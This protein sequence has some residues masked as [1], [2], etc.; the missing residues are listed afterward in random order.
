[1]VGPLDRAPCRSVHSLEHR[2]RK[3]AIKQAGLAAD[4]RRLSTGVAVVPLQVVE[5]VRLYRQIAGQIAT[6]IDNGEFAT[7]SRLPPER[8]LAVLL[9][10]S[11]TSVREALISLEIAGRVDVRV[12]TGIFVRRY[13]AGSGAASRSDSIAASNGHDEGPGP[14]ELLAAR[15]LIEGEIAALAARSIRKAQIGALRE[16]I[17]RMRT[18]GGEF[19]Q[20]DAADRDFHVGIAEATG[21]SSF[22]LVVTALWEQRRGELWARIEKH[23]HTAALREKTL[24]D[25]AAIVTALAAHDSDAAR[26]AMHRHLARVE[27]EFQRKWDAIA[28]G[29]GARAPQRAGLRKRRTNA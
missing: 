23:F 24:S 22:A 2:R 21:N 25:H 20:R 7:G 4:G 29:A 5:P 11:R 1:V 18:H 12:G 14:F 19:E 10:V 15:R 6:L 26:A 13:P 28:P 27:R 8:E 9:G 17:E 16:C 3:G